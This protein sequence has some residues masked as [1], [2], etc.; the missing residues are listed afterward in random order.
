MF[1]KTVLT[2]VLGITFFLF[3]SF[4]LHKFY[5]SVSDINYAPGTST[6]QI[7]S[8]YF[9]DD[10]EALL[11]TRYGIEARF[12]TGAPKGVTDQYL[13]KY[14]NEKFSL[15]INGQSLPLNYIGKEVSLD[16]V[17]IYFETD[18]VKNINKAKAVNNTLEVQNRM[19]TDLFEEQQ[20]IVHIHWNKDVQSVMLHQSNDKALLNLK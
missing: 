20:N 1:K 5:V 15:A 13:E 17:K 11:K 19:L 16:Q 3:T 8:R 6:F 12:E 2:T 4:A 9:T 14:F 7:T 18:P 10:L